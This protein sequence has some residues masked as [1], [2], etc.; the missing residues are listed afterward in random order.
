MNYSK[1]RGHNNLAAVHV[2][3]QLHANV[4][5][6]RSRQASL[7]SFLKENLAQADGNGKLSS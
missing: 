7:L 5:A 4:M 6:T 1:V 3:K 2:Y